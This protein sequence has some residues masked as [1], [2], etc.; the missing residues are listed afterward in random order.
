[1]VFTDTFVNNTS[2]MLEEMRNESKHRVFHPLALFD[3]NTSPVHWTIAVADKSRRNISPNSQGGCT[4]FSCSC[5]HRLDLIKSYFNLIPQCSIRFKHR[6]RAV[7]CW[8]KPFVD[9]ALI[10]K[11]SSDDVQKMYRMGCQNLI[12]VESGHNPITFALPL[13]YVLKDDRSKFIAWTD[14]IPHR[15]CWS[16]PWVS[17]HEACNSVQHFFTRHGFCHLWWKYNI[18]F[19]LMCYSV[20]ASESSLD[21]A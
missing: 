13:A 16:A 8:R 5:R 7:F 18:D 12:Y 15:K 11:Y 9:L 17:F 2:Q 4:R 10:G 3:S 1:M 20:T 21:V 14:S 19:H 6:L